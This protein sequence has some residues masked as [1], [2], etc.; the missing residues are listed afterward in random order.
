M[1]SNKVL[2]QLANI[3]VALVITLYFGYAR[4]LYAETQQ[5]TTRIIKKIE[6]NGNHRISTATIRSS[7]RVKE[8]D[9]YDPQLVSQD[10]DAIW[11]LGFFDNIEVKIEEVPGGLNVVFFV[12]ER[13]VID[14]IQ[15][16]GN[17]KIKSKK[18][19]KQI[20]IKEGDYLKPYLLKLDEDK[21]KELYIK[22]CFNR[23]QVHAE[24]KSINGKTVVVFNIDEGPKIRIAKIDFTGN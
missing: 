3:I 23:I 8:G 10:V 16:H 19:K 1:K 2:L 22:K 15:F 11:S 4:V 9:P 18:L 7:I 6:I 13:S 5:K 17:V 21:I 14:E 24:S 12:T 20:Q